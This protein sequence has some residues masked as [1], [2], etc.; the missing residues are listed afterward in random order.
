MLAIARSISNKIYILGRRIIYSYLYFSPRLI[1]L[2]CLKSTA[3]MGGRSSSGVEAVP[4]VQVEGN[5]V[6]T[7]LLAEGSKE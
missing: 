4:V 2:Y 6:L 1:Y 7:W 3:M 5:E